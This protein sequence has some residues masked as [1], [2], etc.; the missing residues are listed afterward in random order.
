MILVSG[1]T[2]M[3]GSAIVA[4]LLRQGEPVAVLGR[5]R[6]KVQQAFAGTV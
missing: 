2:G 1:G 4:E 3:V 6:A 5:D